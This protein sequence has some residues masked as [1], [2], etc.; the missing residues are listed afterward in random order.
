MDELEA[1]TDIPP[2]L[3]D[4]I[5]EH[6]TNDPAPCGVFYCPQGEAHEW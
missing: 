3:A 6:L 2:E 4:A 1:D 5:A